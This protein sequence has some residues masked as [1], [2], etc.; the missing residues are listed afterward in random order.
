[1]LK[2]AKDLVPGDMVDMVMPFI[3]FTDTEE[4]IPAW[5]DYLYALVDDVRETVT[6]GVPSIEFDYE[7]GAFVTHNA[8]GP[9][10]YGY[11][12]APKEFY[13]EGLV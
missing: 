6:C 2:L 13:G 10:F 3:E 11:G 12:K 4:K 9:T 1:M 5:V 8:Y 7:G